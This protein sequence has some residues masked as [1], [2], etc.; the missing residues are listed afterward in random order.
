MDYDASLYSK[1]YA[2]TADTDPYSIQVD[3]QLWE[4]I[5]RAQQGRRVFLGLQQPDSERPLW[6][7][8]L[9]SPVQDLDGHAGHR[10]YLPLWMIDSGHFHG[11]GEPV[12]IQV[13]DEESF[14]SATRIVLR[15]VDSAFYNAD[16]KA[17]LEQ[18][19]SALGVI[20]TQTLLQIPIQSMDNY[21]VDVFV[22]HTEPADLVLCEGEE[23]A[24]EFEEPVDQIPVPRPPTPIPEVPALLQPVFSTDGQVAA[25]AN[26]FIGE[27][28]R[29]GTSTNQTVG[30]PW[31]NRYRL[32]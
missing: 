24:V 32:R 22:A 6:I 16:V 18:A 7:A 23:V 14:P 12:S 28:Q 2:A 8:P 30:S 1:A 27:G 11:I 15:V 21:S 26:P 25:P 20:R 29:L 9:G 3:Q 31:A 4:E 10:V 13:M 5:I 17:E 19:L